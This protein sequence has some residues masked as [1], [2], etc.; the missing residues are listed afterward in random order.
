MLGMQDLVVFCNATQAQLSGDYEVGY[1]QKVF[2]QENPS[3]AYVTDNAINCC[4]RCAFTNQ[5]NIWVSA[6]AEAMP[7]LWGLLSSCSQIRVSCT[8]YMTAYPGWSTRL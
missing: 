7:S 6:V 1:A 3:N 2:G 8:I 4:L 5:C